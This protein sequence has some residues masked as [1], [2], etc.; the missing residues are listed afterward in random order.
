MASQLSPPHTQLPPAASHRPHPPS[1]PSLTIELGLCFRS[2]VSFHGPTL[3]LTRFATP[4]PF[5]RYEDGYTGQEP[6]IAWFWE[7][8]EAFDDAQR[9][10]LLQFWSGSDGMPAEGFGPLDP[11]FH[12]VAV[13][14][15]YDANDTTAR[16]VSRG[17]GGAGA[18]GRWGGWA[19]GKGG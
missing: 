17:T 11:A 14:R 4:P 3:A 7:V 15:M 2:V 8:V 12:I 1:A 6:I 13:E 18:R 16:L 5:L 19:P 10:Q 9:R